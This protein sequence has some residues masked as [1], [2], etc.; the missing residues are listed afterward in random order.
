MQTANSGFRPGFWGLVRAPAFVWAA[1][2]PADRARA[3]HEWVAQIPKG[4]GPAIPAEALRREN[5]YD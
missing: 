5:I 1:L 2:P 4:S 3:F